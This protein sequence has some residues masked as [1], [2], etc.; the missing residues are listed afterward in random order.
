MHYNPSYKVSPGFSPRTTQGGCW[1]LCG[2]SGSGLPGD[3]T[4]E[5][6]AVCDAA[7]YEVPCREAV[8]PKG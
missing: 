8:T 6:V 3:W 5:S 7:L 1:F 2:K 4:A